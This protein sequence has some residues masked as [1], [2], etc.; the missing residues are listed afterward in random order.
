MKKRRIKGS[1]LAVC[2][3]ATMVIAANPVVYAAPQ[4][5]EAAEQEENSTEVIE[6]DDVEMFMEIV[7]NC[8][9]D[10]WSVD[11]ELKLNADLDLSPVNFEG[12]GYFNGIFDG[13]GHTIS[14]VNLHA[15]GSNYGF[16]RYVG[17]LGTVK[18][19]S[20]T[21]SISA[22]GSGKNIGGI[23]G[24]NYG[25]IENCSF[26][27]TV[28][29]QSATGGIAGINK[30]AGRILSCTSTADVL[31][32][33]YTGGISGKNEGEISACKSGSSVNVEELE[34]R[35]NLGDVELGSLNLTQRIVNR[36]DM[37]GIAGNSTGIISSCEN[38]GTIGFNHTGYNVGGI[39]GSQSGIIMDCVNNGMIYGRKDVGG[40][41][42]QAEP[43]ME[44]EY[45][46]D[47]VESTK[48]DISRLN[49]TL[50]GISNSI[51]QTSAE[52][53]NYL[54]SMSEQ[55]HASMNQISGS[56][57]DLSNSVAQDHPEA[58]GYV[59]NINSALDNIHNIQS[60]E[61]T[62]SQEQ[63]DAIEQNLGTIND[64]LGNL[65][66]TYAGTGESAE[67]L[68][69][70][71]ST[72]VQKQGEQKT[73]Q[74][75]AESVDRG[76]QS[77]ANGIGSAA[78]QMNQ[79]ADT[80]GD[81]LSL[82]TGEEDRVQDISSVETAEN[83]DGVISNCRNNGKI[84]G[85]LNAGGITGTMNIEYESDPELD[86]DL[87]GNLNI[88]LRSTVNDVVIHCI[89]Y[90]TVNAKKNC[91]G[92]ITGLQ[93]L[94][95]IH[96]CEGYGEIESESGNY[97]GGIAGQ[98]AAG[99]QKSYSLCNVSGENYVGGICGSGYTITDSISVSSIESEGESL[100]SIAGELEEEGTA[101]NN[102]YVSETLHGVDDISYLG[103]AEER[104]YE[105][106]M[107]LADI[108][109][110][111]HQ[112]TISFETE[113]GEKLGEK[114][115]PYGGRLAE[116]D[117]PKVPE[118]EGYYV[119]WKEHEKFQNICRNF[120]A[121]A[122]YVPWT[123]SIAGNVQNEDGKELFLVEG[124]FYQDMKLELTETE[125]PS[126]L[127]ENATVEYA[128]DWKI[129][130]G[131]EKKFDTLE[132]HF[133][134]PAGE[135]QAALWMKQDGKWNVMKTIPDGSYLTAEIPYGAEFAM[136]TVPQSYLG[137]YA[138]G[139]AAVLILV[140]IF[141]LRKRKKR[142]AGRDKKE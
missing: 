58:Q 139:G 47:K 134:A 5:E 44:S 93:E 103:S 74:G 100:G 84:C 26:V 114:K 99:I 86:L 27:G 136:I 32:T 125:K 131:T 83:V 112:V 117:L 13:N 98:S 102:L 119:R 9:Y 42:G 29:G 101:A 59:D 115:I 79:I 7:E 43:Y 12:I 141:V 8:K 110:G 137:Y 76:I 60:Q 31:A 17:E 39:A 2:L 66:G 87:K 37:G 118:K 24:T 91:A 138:A 50:K 4:S 65:K 111:F 14:N 15:K 20:V 1:M 135:K 106:I 97:L 72:E 33:N 89:N 130:E 61:G 18:N 70:S 75:I 48:E 56:L 64:N 81:D 85:D 49:R 19:L 45:L 120:T 77:V 28:T 80:I 3:A 67:A 104:S 36:N 16:F 10:S 22:S 30:E 40:I 23:V 127:P 113:D 128:Y 25:V 46:K 21:G 129:T 51:S 92:G 73:L 132:G 121:Y 11:K 35:L 108:P 6:I 90:G 71:I 122:E 54:N 57:N 96:D 62:L 63:V 107:E 41:V 140:L 133:Y 94:G 95:L 123:E 55:Y 88:T 68:V 78:H 126:G 53:K 142:K 109:E 82:L 124:E 52:T 105:E 34:T 38:T 116:S 69:D